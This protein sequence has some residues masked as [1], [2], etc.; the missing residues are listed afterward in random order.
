ML[1]RLPTLLLQNITS[2]CPGEAI[3]EDQIASASPFAAALNAA[4]TDSGQERTSRILLNV[5]ARDLNHPEHVGLVGAVEKGRRAYCNFW[6]H[7]LFV[8]KWKG[9][10]HA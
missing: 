10:H 9:G 8:K 5:S 1:S 7:V 4:S 3:A 2:E 6:S